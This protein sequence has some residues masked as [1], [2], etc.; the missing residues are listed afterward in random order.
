MQE[1]WDACRER[2]LSLE[3]LGEARGLSTQVRVPDLHRPGL[4]LVGHFYHHHP[5]RIQVFGETEITFL[6]TRSSDE[7]AEVLNALCADR[8]PAIVVTRDLAA[9]TELLDA[10]KSHDIAVF[11]TPFDTGT[12]I[13]HTTRLLEDLL[14]PTAVLHGVLVDVFGVGVMITGPSGIGKSE[15]ALELVLR[16]HRLV[17]DDMVELK[18]RPREGLIG[19]SME[20]I[21][22]HMEIRGL[23]IIN[24]QDLFGVA[25]VR[26]QKR[27]E[28]IVA[29]EHWNPDAYYDRLGSDDEQVRV[30]LGVPVD[31]A[32]VP[33]R[34]GRT[35]S[36][37]IEVAA[38]NRILKARGVDSAKRFQDRLLEEI[39]RASPDAPPPTGTPLRESSE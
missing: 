37:I 20:L 2:G 5:E 9:P 4:A 25:A 39:R 34:P 30:I 32:R 7:R 3:L 10:A 12:F 27:L 31:E 35:L 1:A 11:G 17:A 16:G 14:A 19:R 8:V 6:G 36:E 13:R 15:C 23:G 33:V 22:H 38:R 29:L 18:L 26:D 21:K 24:V 28:L